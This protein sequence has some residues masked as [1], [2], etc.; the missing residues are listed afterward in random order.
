MYKRKRR[1]FFAIDPNHR[2]ILLQ[3]IQNSEKPLARKTIEEELVSHPQV[4]VKF[5][6]TMRSALQDQLTWE[7]KLMRAKGIIFLIGRGMNAAYTMDKSLLEGNKPTPASVVR[8]HL[9]LPP[10]YS[11]TAVVDYMTILVNKQIEMETVI[12]NAQDQLDRISQLQTKAQKK[13]QR[14]IKAGID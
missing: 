1:G 6:Q 7:L 8:K 5:T 11:R 3:I 12:E 13:L 9:R 4:K 14:L 2:T 10:L